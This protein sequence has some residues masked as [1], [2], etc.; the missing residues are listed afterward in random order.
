[1]AKRWGV[2]TGAIVSSAIFGLAHAQANIS[3]YTWLLGLLLCA[4]YV[5]LKSIIPGMALHMLN[6]YLAFLALTSAH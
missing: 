1:M 2:I 5:R 4:M 6:N 3:I